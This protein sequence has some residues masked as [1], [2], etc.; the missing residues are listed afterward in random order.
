VADLNRAIKAGDAAAREQ[1]AS[2]IKE[3]ARQ[4]NAA[5]DSVAKGQASRPTVRTTFSDDFP[6]EGITY[7]V[8]RGDTLSSIAAK[9][10]AS[11]KDIQNANRLSD[12]GNIQVGQNLFIPGAK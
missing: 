4:T 7:T 10:K 12:A 5:V 3:L 6:K 11:V 1:A 8:Q 9:F 2:A